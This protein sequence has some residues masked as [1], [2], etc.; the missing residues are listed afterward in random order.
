MSIEG[1]RQVIEKYTSNN[2]KSIHIW[3]LDI[4][5]SKPGG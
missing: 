5:I 3:I 4:L 2:I 1:S